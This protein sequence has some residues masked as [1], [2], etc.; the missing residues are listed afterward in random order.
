MERLDLAWQ[1]RSR[2]RSLTD[3]GLE[4]PSVH[5]AAL[6]ELRIAGREDLK[7]L[8]SLQLP[9]LRRLCVTGC[10]LDEAPERELLWATLHA[11]PELE[12]LELVNCWCTDS[13]Q[14]GAFVGLRRLVIR[15]CELATSLTPSL[16]PALESLRLAAIE[17]TGG[18]P[19]LLE[20]ASQGPLTELG[21]E[22]C[23]LIPE[24][25]SS[26]ARLP[27]AR[28]GLDAAVLDDEFIEQLLRSP[29]LDRST[30][31][32]LRGCAMSEAA[33]ERLRHHAGHARLEGLDDRCPERARWLGRYTYEHGGAHGGESSALV[34]ERGPLGDLRFRYDWSGWWTSGYDADGDNYWM[35]GRVDVEDEHLDR[36]L[37]PTREAGGHLD[38]YAGVS[39]TCAYLVMSDEGD[40]RLLHD[41]PEAPHGEYVGP[42][43]LELT[44]ES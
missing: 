14:L 40:V 29:V 23:E 24:Y 20:L 7:H 30:S 13:L 25:L 12:A 21:L 34:I 18:V 43:E 19:Q 35:E 37:L 39:D 36:L 9:A 8:R 11:H 31:L 26:L 10:D 5:A 32:S 16:P 22:G 41:V 15:A 27:L 2:S 33:R 6:R 1:G 4:S 44:R 17:D 42:F 3:C 28:L 38:S